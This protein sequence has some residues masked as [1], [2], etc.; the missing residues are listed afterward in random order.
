M[1]PRRRFLQGLVTALAALLPAGFAR[2]APAAYR[3]LRALAERYGLHVTTQTGESVVLSNRHISLTFYPKLQHSRVNTTCFWLNHPMLPDGR[4]W[5]ISAT[6][7]EKIIDPLMRPKAYLRQ[8]KNRAVVID[9][10]HGD[11]DIGAQGPR[12][13]LLEKDLTLDIA[14]R[15]RSKLANAGYRCLLTRD[16]DYF[17]PLDDRPARAAK[18]GADAMVSIHFNSTGNPR[19]CGV[20]SFI[21]TPSGSAST[22]STRSSR[23]NFSGNKFDAQNSIMAYYV[24]KRLRTKIDAPD[25]GVRHA[26][27]AVLRGAACPAM[28]VEC[29]FL[30]HAPT[31]K[32]LRGT[33]YRDQIAQGVSD[34]LVDYFQAVA[35]ARAHP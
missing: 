1:M 4:S 26:R 3:S 8:A 30:S 16:R 20:E 5:A 19:A 23:S 32:L 9:A 33:W 11:G 24:Q 10:G 13:G 21:L 35:A 18:L 14:Q 22:G 12:T 17:I 15:L 34:G 29:G 25:R 28:L 31:E 6:D 2:A 7:A 27:F